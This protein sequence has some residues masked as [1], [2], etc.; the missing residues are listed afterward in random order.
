MYDLELVYQPLEDRVLISTVLGHPTRP[1]HRVLESEPSTMCCHGCVPSTLAI[2]NMVFAVC[3]WVLLL[4][5]CSSAVVGLEGAFDFNDDDDDL[6]WGLNL[7][8][9]MSG[10]ASFIMFIGL[11]IRIVNVARTISQSDQA[12]QTESPCCKALV[13]IFDFIVLGLTGTG[14]LFTYEASLGLALW[15]TFLF[16]GLLWLFITDCMRVCNCCWYQQR[17]SY[18]PIPQVVSVET[19]WQQHEQ[20]QHQHQQQQ[21]HDAYLQQNQAQQQPHYKQQAQA[22]QYPQTNMYAASTDH[23]QQQNSIQQPT[24][25]VQASGYALPPTVAP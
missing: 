20:L 16:F 7:A 6:E 3:M 9:Y 8:A 15:P 4:N 23:A 22:Q 17:Q 5:W 21:H 2:F 25:S 10:G 19:T 24:G 1:F 11:I 12:D 14:V 18:Q 13:A